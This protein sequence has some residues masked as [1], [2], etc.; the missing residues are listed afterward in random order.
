[1]LS[2]NLKITISKLRTDLGPFFFSFYESFAESLNMPPVNWRLKIEIQ[3]DLF[4]GLE[5]ARLNNYKQ[6]FLS[7][8]RIHKEYLK[9]YPQN[10]N[11]P[12]SLL[13]YL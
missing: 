6:F 3:Q 2:R 10:K 9:C 12:I 7:V 1:M 8:R 4:A 13:D 5:Q 11:N